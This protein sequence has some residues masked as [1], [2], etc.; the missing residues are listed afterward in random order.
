MVP[1][2]KYLETEILPCC[3]T[4]FVFVESKPESV[5]VGVVVPSRRNPARRMEVDDVT[6]GGEEHVQAGQDD[7]MEYRTANMKD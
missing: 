5:V 1:V 3:W 2:H 6:D 4:I 7:R